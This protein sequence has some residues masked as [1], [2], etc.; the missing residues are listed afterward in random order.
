MCIRDRNKIGIYDNIPVL[1]ILVLF[2][3]ALYLFPKTSNIGFFLICSYLGGVI[4][5]EVACGESPILGIVLTALFYI[6]TMIRRPD[7][8]GVDF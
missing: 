2:L 1:G 3:V 4:V 7:I 6:G 8:S 5:G